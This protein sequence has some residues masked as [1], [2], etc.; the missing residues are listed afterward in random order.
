MNSLEWEKPYMQRCIDILDPQGDVLEIGWGCGYSAT[1]IVE[2]SPKSY[3][4]IECCPDTVERARTWAKQYPHVPIT[5][6]Q[7]TWESEIHNL[8]IFDELFFDDY[9]LNTEV[10]H[11]PHELCM[12]NHRFKIFIDLCIQN[13]TR[14]GSKI[15]A[16]LNDEMTELQL[17]SDAI[18]FIDITF[19]HMD[20]DIPDNCN[21][22]ANLLN[23]CTIPLVTKINDMS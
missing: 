4:V 21:Y 14:V 6:I 15:S 18:P 7:G 3:T 1:H 19:T 2:K 10:S 12:S 13:H 9:P 17:S 16:Y 23:K 5:I 20:I 8:G 22:R 11:T